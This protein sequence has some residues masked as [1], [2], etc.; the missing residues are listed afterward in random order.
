M[1][2]KKILFDYLFFGLLVFAI[3]CSIGCSSKKR[4]IKPPPITAHSPLYQSYQNEIKIPI[5]CGKDPIVRFINFSYLFE[6]SLY[7]N[8]EMST[9]VKEGPLLEDVIIYNDEYEI[10]YG[11]TIANKQY[12]ETSEMEVKRRSQYMVRGQR[13]LISNLILNSRKQVKEIKEN[14]IW[15]SLEFTLAPEDI[16]SLLA[17]EEI[18]FSLFTKSC[19]ININPTRSQKK[20]LQTFLNKIIK[21]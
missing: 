1:E 20:N 18:S 15:N 7:V 5:N 19:E 2:M 16:L 8:I 21:E 14:Q 6:D 11:A 4:T 13:S 17:S 10:S 12:I 9:G 3:S